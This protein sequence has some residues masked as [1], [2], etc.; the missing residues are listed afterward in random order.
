MPVDRDSYRQLAGSF[1][2]GVTI[3]TT[4]DADGAPKGLT[5]QSFIGLST[6]PPLILVAIDK[7]SRTLVSLE[8]SRTF[9]LN[10][11]KVGAEEIST[12]FASKADDKFAGLAWRP[13]TVADGAPILHESS[14]AYAE[15]AVI[16]RKDVGDHVIFIGRVDGGEVLGGVPLMYYRRMYAAW[17]EE[18]PAPR[19]I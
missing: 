16:Q 11:L 7:T 2:T 15:C 5:T 6:E 18:K 10:F 8:R 4:R 17:P 14:V 1:P 19:A 9:V 12:K 13:S 3:V